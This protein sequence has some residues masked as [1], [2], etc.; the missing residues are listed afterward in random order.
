[1]D[2]TLYAQVY[3]TFRINDW[4]KQNDPCGFISPNEVLGHAL[5]CAT[6]VHFVAME[7]SAGAVNKDALD[8]N[9]AG[10]MAPLGAT[11][12]APMLALWP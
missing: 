5:L 3:N 9:P 12:P 10:A 2:D 4:V 11:Y 7:A 1:M 6:Y 8:P